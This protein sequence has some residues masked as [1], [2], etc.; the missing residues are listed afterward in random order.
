MRVEQIN[1]WI[2]STIMGLVSKTRYLFNKSSFYKDKG[3]FEHLHQALKV[4]LLL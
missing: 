4:N 3:W 1:L 2:M